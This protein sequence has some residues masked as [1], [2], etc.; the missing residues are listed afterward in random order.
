MTISRGIIRAVA[1]LLLISCICTITG[2]V[3]IQTEKQYPG[4]AA[5]PN[6]SPSSVGTAVF[7]NSTTSDLTAP[8]KTNSW[9]SPVLWADSQSL[10][11]PDYW[12]IIHG[13]NHPLYQLPVYPLPWS[14]YYCKTTKAEADR[15]GNILNKIEAGEPVSDVPQGLFVRT[16]P[17]FPLYDTQQQ[18]PDG[19]HD[20][21]NRQYDIYALSGQY[22]APA[23]QIDPGFNASHIRVS[24]MGDYDAGFI[25]K[26]SDD[27]LRPG[28]IPAD[29][30][31]SIDSVRGSPFLHL[32]AGN[33][34]SLNMTIWSGHGAPGTTGNLTVNGKEISYVVITRPMRSYGNRLAGEGYNRLFWENQT[35]VA[36]YPSGTAGYAETNLDPALNRTNTWMS[37]RTLASFSFTSQAGPHYLTLASVPSPESLDSVS[38]QTL[39]AA[40]FRYPTGS[41]VTYG[42]NQEKAEVTATYSLST[43]DVLSLGG[44]PV[45]GLLPIHYGSFF[46]GSSVLTSAQDWVKNGS[47]TPLVMDSVLG[48]V[49][50]LKGSSFTCTYRYSGMLPYIPGLPAQDTEGRKNL[51]QWLKNVEELKATGD[52]SAYKYTEMNLGPGLDT[53]NAGQ[54]I[55]TAANLYRTAQGLEPSISDDAADS[56]RRS[57]SLFFADQPKM[58][59]ANTSTNQAPYYAYYDSK[60]ATIILYPASVNPGGFPNEERK[61]QYDGYGTATKLNDHHYTWGYFINAAAQVAMDN[62]SWMQEH[63]NVINQLVF[64]VAYDPAMQDRAQ[65]PYPK[66]R[67]WDPYTGHCEAS[68]MTYEYYSGNSDES[69]SE[70]LHF[71]AGVINW[72]TASGQPDIQTLGIVHY[73]QAVYSYFTFWHDSFGTYQKLWNKVKPDLEKIK[74]GADNLWVSDSYCPQIWDSKV[75]QSTFFGVNPSGSTAITVLPMTGASFYHAMNPSMIE[76]YMAAFSAYVTKWNIDPMKPPNGKSWLDTTAPFKGELSYYVEIAPW[77]ALVNPTAALQKYFPLDPF[78]AA[79]KDETYNVKPM[80]LFSRTEK[81]TAETYHFIRFLQDYGTPDPLFAHATNTPYY[82][83]FVKDGVRTYVGYNPTE[84][85][86][87][88]TFSDGKGITG[89]APHKFGFWPGGFPGKLQASFTA[90]PSGGTAPLNVNFTDTSNGSITSWAWDFGDGATSGIPNPVH[91][92]TSPG[93]YRVTLTVTDTKTTTNS[94]TRPI[95]VR[96]PGMLPGNFTISTL[97]A[98]TG[99]NGL[100]PSLAMSGDDVA[101]LSFFNADTPRPWVDGQTTGSIC[102]EKLD[103]SQGVLKPVKDENVTSMKYKKYNAPYPQPEWERTSLAYN[104]ATGTPMISYTEIGAI[105][106]KLEFT[107]LKPD[108][109]WGKSMVSDAFPMPP[110]VAVTREG[111]PAIAYPSITGK[112]ANYAFPNGDYTH[113]NWGRGMIEP[114]G[115]ESKFVPDTYYTTLLLTGSEQKARV[116]YYRESAHEIRIATL[117]DPEV[118]S[119]WDIQTVQSGVSAGGVSA[120]YNADTNKIGVCW[121]DLNTKSLQFIEAT[122]GSAWGTAEKVDDNGSNCSLAYGPANGILSGPGISYY[123]NSTRELRFA[124]RETTGWEH[125]TIDDNGSG[126]SSSLAYTSEGYPH[127]AYRNEDENALKYAYLNQG[128]G[129]EA[130]FSSDIQSGQVPLTVHFYD[131]TINKT[132]SSLADESGGIN[133]TVDADYWWD[134][135]GDGEWDQEDVEKPVYT[136]N[137]TG[138]YDVTMLIHV[139]ITN[140]YE[141][142]TSDV[143][144]FWGVADMDDYIT[145]NPSSPVTA[146]FTATPVSGT[147]PLEVRFTDTSDGSPSSWNWTFGDGTGSHDQNPIHTYSGIGRYTVTLETTGA[148]GSDITRKPSCIGVNSGK[149][150]GQTG[151]LQVHSVPAG[152]DLYVDG[153]LQGQTPADELIT[154]VGERAILVHLDGYQNWTETVQVSPGAVKVVPTIRLRQE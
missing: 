114:A 12:A 90:T 16:M 123:N 76:S 101:Y 54:V 108:N 48:E 73:T 110:S 122:P 135:T 83:T 4:T 49:R 105:P 88:I 127:I 128:T 65:F 11:Y 113:D 52:K 28:T 31:L 36:F 91:T 150:T 126:T 24:R 22:S 72:G 130:S 46:G 147:P 45:Q 26:S 40:A 117:N 124:W 93:T 51:S 75:K 74:P 137:K 89:V 131:N 139:I 133:V 38:L 68:G 154:Q 67:M 144:D 18:T 81:S 27:P 112:N 125:V 57:I 71:W 142:N 136:Y 78:T 96:R 39:A 100:F 151:M 95:S 50:Y 8:Y 9:V 21:N 30:T 87:N 43:A 77:Y 59:V 63:K 140:R 98:G 146:D 107:W 35:Y 15:F 120:A 29:A 111:V 118:K 61:L 145:V 10:I 121:Y 13:D 60:A 115:D 6:S 102:Y 141:D 44:T 104:K 2:A 70:E 97:H 1:L 23:I 62:S 58:L 14:L 109:S 138:T 119:K 92:F 85:T 153:V 148:E 80:E 149:L 94:Y 7:Q 20:A 47:G 25:L 64:D 32:T 129:L 103:F 41:T 84:T 86:M 66:M 19:G 69:I 152:A 79:K 143:V 56:A 99:T 82:M 132:I 37:D 106:H 134:M 34:P 3:K 5:N 42:Y 116:V 55:W 17:V 33:I 53:Y